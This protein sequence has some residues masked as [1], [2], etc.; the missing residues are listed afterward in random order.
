MLDRLEE[1]QPRP[2]SEIGTSSYLGFEGNVDAVWAVV[3][4][5]RYHCSVRSSSAS[6]SCHGLTCEP[7]V[8]TMPVATYLPHR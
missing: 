1:L 4:S 6:P 8:P 2:R 3:T 5:A 7:T